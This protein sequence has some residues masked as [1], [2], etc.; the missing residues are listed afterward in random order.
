MVLL[1]TNLPQT[2][3]PKDGFTSHQS[4]TDPGA[5]NG[6]TSHQS[7]TDSGPKICFYFAPVCHRPWRQKMVLLRTNL[8]QTLAPKDGF[9]S[10]Q[11][12]TDVGLRLFASATVPAPGPGSYLLI[13]DNLLQD[14]TLFLVT[15]SSELEFEIFM[16]P[17]LILYFI[18]FEGE[19]L[20][21]DEIPGSECNFMQ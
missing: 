6:F 14:L 1:S 18:V 20:E 16:P 4:A 15:C 10:H 21:L 5:K 7:A 2:L 19:T 11:S 3:A 12:A 9:T 8:P 13:V 17:T